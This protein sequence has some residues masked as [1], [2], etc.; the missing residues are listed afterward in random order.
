MNSS[1]TVDIESLTI[2]EKI[3]LMEL[4]WRDI[5]KNP[6]DIQVP[7]WHLKILAE[8]E[9]ALANGETEYIDFDDAMAEIRE[10]I[11]SRRRQ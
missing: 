2:A 7:E 10:E 9:K 1:T 8:R 5:A 3:G 4:L 6:A 11:E